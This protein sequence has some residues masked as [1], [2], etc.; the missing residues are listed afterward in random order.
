MC[1]I[2][3]RGQAPLRGP[4][5]SN[6]WLFRRSLT[7][8]LSLGIYLCAFPMLAKRGHIHGLDRV[9]GAS[10]NVLGSNP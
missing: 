9:G 3:V 1:S 7:E 2:P 6:L 5:T 10:V 8:R 4:R